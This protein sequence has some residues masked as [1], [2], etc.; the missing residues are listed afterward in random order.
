LAALAQI[1]DIRAIPEAKAILADTLEYDSLAKHA[2]GYLET[3][4]E[5]GEANNGADPI[6]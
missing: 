3:I 1:G 5:H 4:E 2:K 6:R